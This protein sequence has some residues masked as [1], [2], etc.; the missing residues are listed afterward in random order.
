MQNTSI[1]APRADVY[2]RITDA[3]VAALEQGVRPWLKPWSVEHTAGR[4]TRP[5]RHNSE[6]YNGINV[7][8]L[9]AEAVDKGFA[10]PI[11]MTFKQALE[12]DAHVRK[13]EHGSPVVYADRLTRTDTDD[14]S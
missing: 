6:P 14:W 4:I 9:W 10:S 13:G 1:T 3:I 8:M 12:L 7:L 5:L 2:T 11:W